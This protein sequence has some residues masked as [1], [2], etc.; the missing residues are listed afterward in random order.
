MQVVELMAQHFARWAGS[1]S[2]PEMA[3]L[4]T[5]Q[6]RKLLKQLPA[7]RFRTAIRTLVTALERSCST[8]LAA[9]SS[10]PSKL[11]DAA[12]LQAFLAAVKA[13]GELCICMHAAGWSQVCACK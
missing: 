1:P 2:M 6:L 7:E 13:G 4:A 5:V 9:R 10:R 11:S 3:H 12:A 8:V